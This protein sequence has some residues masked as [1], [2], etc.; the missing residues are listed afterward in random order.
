MFWGFPELY[1]APK[2]P[3]SLLQLYFL[4]F[5]S[6]NHVSCFE[7]WFRDHLLSYFTPQPAKFFAECIRMAI[8]ATRNIVHIA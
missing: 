2:K 4:T 5:P 6:P 3:T 1:V 7:G 8:P